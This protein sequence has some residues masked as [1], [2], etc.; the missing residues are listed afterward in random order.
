MHFDFSQLNLQYLIQARDLACRNPTLVAPL[1]AIPD[2]MATLLT[3]LTPQE[4]A[5]VARIKPP[6]LTPRQE[7]WWWKR[8]LTA[9]REGRMDEIDVVMEHLSLIAAPSDG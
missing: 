4:L 1:L 5:H 8:L 2:D 9:L 7:M 3:E 6:L